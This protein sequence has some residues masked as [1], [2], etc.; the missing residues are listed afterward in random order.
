MGT[1]KKPATD[2]SMAM[3]TLAGDLAS[4]NN[5]SPED[6]LL[7]L[8]SGLS[9]E[10]EPMRRFGVALSET[11]VKAKAM[12]M[13]IEGV[14]GVLTEAQKVQAR[15]AIIMAQTSMAQGDFARTSDGMANKERILA[16]KMDDLKTKFGQVLLPIKMLVADGV[17]KLIDALP[18]LKAAFDGLMPPATIASIKADLLPALKDIGKFLQSDVLPQVKEFGAMALEMGTAI[19]Q[20]LAPS[21]DTLADLWKNA[22]RPAP[23][24]IA[25]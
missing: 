23:E 16:A 9:G 6:V 5:A 7:A 2:M 17:I 18:K 25:P 15:Y 21:L 19:A 11:A 14:D 12:E 13:G 24:A 4:F 10:S 20:F 3:V 22:L 1:G 8:R